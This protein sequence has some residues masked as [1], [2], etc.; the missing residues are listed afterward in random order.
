METDAWIEETYNAAFAEE[1]R[2]LERRCAHDPSCTVADLQGILDALYISQGND[3]DGRGFRGDAII[4]AQ[5]AA[6]EHFI[7]EMS[8][9]NQVK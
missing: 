8:K 7:S 2:G 1:L 5:I 9:R 4:S 3:Q 6:Y